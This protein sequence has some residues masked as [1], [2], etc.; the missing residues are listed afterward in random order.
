M[1]TSV[2]AQLSTSSQEPERQERLIRIK[3]D[4]KLKEFKKARRQI[5][6]IGLSA[7]STIL[8]ITW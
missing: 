7:T 2:T 5:Q 6:S 4:R 3:Y 8:Q 1:E